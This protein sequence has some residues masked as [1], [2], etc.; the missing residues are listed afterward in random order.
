MVCYT[1][2]NVYR[3]STRRVFTPTVCKEVALATC[4]VVSRF[5]MGY[6]RSASK[7]QATGTV[8]SRM[9]A[10]RESLT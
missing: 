3:R 9:G 8:G 5:S 10:S 6:I 4:C 7:S 2:S 1:W